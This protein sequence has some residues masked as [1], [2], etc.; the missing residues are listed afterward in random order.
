MSLILYVR[1]LSTFHHPTQVRF[2]EVKTQEPTPGNIIPTSLTLIV[3]PASEAQTKSFHL[4]YFTSEANTEPYCLS[5][6]NNCSGV[7]DG[8][9]LKRERTKT[10]KVCGTPDTLCW[11]EST[12]P[13][14]GPYVLTA[15]LEQYRKRNFGERTPR[16]VKDDA[17]DL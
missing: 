2:I 8:N 5:F 12:N 13:R 1:T 3:F 16:C 14:E 17:G 10:R 7:R 6:Q 15:F 11:G 4:R 9:S